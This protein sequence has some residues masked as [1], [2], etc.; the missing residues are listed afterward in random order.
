MSCVL[1]G[2]RWARGSSFQAILADLVDKESLKQEL[3][4]TAVL[5]R[6]TD[7][8]AFLCHVAGVRS[9]AGDRPHAAGEL[10]R[11]HQLEPESAADGEQAQG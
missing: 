9:E 7:Q 5:S 4:T 3:Y 6:K 10:R 11:S 2:G 8:S 1:L